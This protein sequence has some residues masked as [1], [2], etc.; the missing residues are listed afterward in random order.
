M[1]DIAGIRGAGTFVTFG[2]NVCMLSDGIHGR[3]IVIDTGDWFTTVALAAGEVCAGRVDVSC[4]IN[5]AVLAA[6]T[7]IKFDSQV[8]I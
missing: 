6:S 7:I 1:N 4:F 3:K 8:G 2:T 5:V